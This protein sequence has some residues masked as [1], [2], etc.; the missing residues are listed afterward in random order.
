MKTAEYWRAAKRAL[1]IDSDY[2]LAKR[3]EITRASAS[4]L[5]NGHS[6]MSNTTAA[7][8]AEILKLDP[9]QVI[10]DCELERGTNDAF[11]RRIR[12]A[13][14][15]AFCAIGAVALFGDLSSAGDLTITGLSLVA[16][17][18]SSVSSE[19]GIYIVQVGAAIAM[20]VLLAIATLSDALS[21]F[22]YRESR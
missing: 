5:V 16:A 2:A 4:L 19:S 21:R 12:D 6:T 22:P 9:L 1:K 11:W 8:I 17:V 13:A 15:F 7:K 14:M 3:L 18:P 20:L 10:A